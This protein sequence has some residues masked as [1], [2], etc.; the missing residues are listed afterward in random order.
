MA[1][2]SA[3]RPSRPCQVN[4]HAGLQ[5]TDDHE[6][7]GNVVLRNL[8]SPATGSQRS[9]RTGKL[10]GGGIS[11]LRGKSKPAGITPTTTRLSLFNVTDFLTRFG[12]PPNWFRHR[13]S[14]ITTTLFFARLF[15]F[16]GEA[17]AQNRLDSHRP[18]ELGDH[19][20]R[21]DPDQFAVPIEV[22]QR[23]GDA[24]ELLERP[25]AWRQSTRSS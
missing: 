23:L 7:P 11:E 17:P 6:L 25:C 8:A 12:S 22:H 24:G 20:H 16:G 5:A 15:F 19:C 14:L 21:T 13:P 2:C 18:K 9:D 1:A 4:G 10:Q 3:S